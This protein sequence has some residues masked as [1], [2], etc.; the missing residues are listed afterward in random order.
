MN[1]FDQRDSA[2]IF[3]NK[4][5]DEKL[6]FENLVEELEKNTQLDKKTRQKLQS[7]LKDEI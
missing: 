1:S 6:E 4:L 7:E 5:K 3:I 2:R